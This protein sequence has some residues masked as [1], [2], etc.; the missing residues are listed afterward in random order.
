MLGDCRWFQ[1]VTTSVQKNQHLSQYSW[2]HSRY[3]LM[4]HNPISKKKISLKKIVDKRKQLKLDH[5]PLGKRNITHA[6]C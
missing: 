6:H 3:I 1:R 4:V 2:E 5:T